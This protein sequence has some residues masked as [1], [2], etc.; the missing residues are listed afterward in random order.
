MLNQVKAHFNPFGD[1]FNLNATQVHG[2]RR[3]YQGQG[4][5]FG[6]TEWYSKVMY[7]K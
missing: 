7:V 5:G 3:M 4:N 1:S 2:L 6:H